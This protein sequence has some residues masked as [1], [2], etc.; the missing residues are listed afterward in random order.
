MESKKTAQNDE[1]SKAKTP[2]ELE[3]EVLDQ[4]AGGFVSYT[5]PLPGEDPVPVP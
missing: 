5:P 1:Q 3:N 2:T 4:V